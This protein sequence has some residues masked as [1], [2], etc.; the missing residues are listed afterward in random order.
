MSFK[1]EELLSLRIK[2]HDLYEKTVQ[3]VLIEKRQEFLDV[4]ED[5]FRE[6]GFVIRKRNDSVRASFDI[7][8]F[9]AFT[10]E[11]GKI[12]IMKGKE[13]IANI[14]IH[15]D[16]DTDPDFYYTGSNFEIR[17]DSPL[18]ILESIFQI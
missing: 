12:M 6:R 1:K 17:F 2:D 5:Y 13:E 8:H 11:T 9:K 3:T 14:Y 18:A 16:G 4:F 15:F 7:L 10:D